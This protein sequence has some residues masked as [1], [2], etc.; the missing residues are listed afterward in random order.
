MTVLPPFAEL[1]AADDPPLDALALAIAAEL[2]EI[3]ATSA[4][5]RLDALGAE[6]AAATAG[7]A[8]RP[9]DEAR[10]CAAL[11]GGTHGFTGDRDHYDDPANSML[12]VVLERRRGLPILLSVVYVE[13]AR[14]AG[15]RLAGIGLA[16][17][18]VV[19]HVAA[20]PPLLLDPFDG[21]AFVAADVPAGAA[22]PWRST[23]IA[24]RMLNNLVAALDRRGDVGG[25]IRAAA[26]RLELPAPDPL[27]ARLRAELRALRARL[28]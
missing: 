15:V 13:V 3:D 8:G 12:D 19:G 25:A 27:R 26:M 7:A 2:R 28:N 22:R 11:L 21:G 20:A 6:L 16:G 4:L 17:H 10:A 9:E 14:R 24:L 5:A 23:E 1:A 18:F